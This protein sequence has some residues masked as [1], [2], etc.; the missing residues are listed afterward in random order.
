MSCMPDNLPN[1]SA[2][3]SGCSAPCLLPAH[4]W[5]HMRTPSPTHTPQWDAAHLAGPQHTRIWV[6][7]R[8]SPQHTHKGASQTQPTTHLNAAHIIDSALAH[9][10]SKSKHHPAPGHYYCI[11]CGHCSG[12]AAP[13]TLCPLQPSAE[14]HCHPCA[15][16]GPAPKPRSPLPLCP[17]RAPVHHQA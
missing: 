10:A 14:P 15:G 12:K 6:Q 7:A 5:A 8:H 17:R 13:I 9:K 2:T 1:Y 16:L 4:E 11:A 3:S